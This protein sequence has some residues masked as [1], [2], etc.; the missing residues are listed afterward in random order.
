MSTIAAISTA[1]GVGGIGVIRIS[2]PDSIKIAGKIFKSAD[3]MELSDVKG[4]NAKYGKVY[5]GDSII[6]EAIAL[7]F[8]SPHSYTGEDVVEISCHGGIYIVRKVLDIV[9]KNGA[10]LAESGE[11]TKRAFLN[12][13]I[14]L[15]KAEAIINLIA[16]QGEK[17]REIAISGMEGYINKIIDK[18]KRNLIDIIS[19][20]DVW[21]DYPDDEVYEVDRNKLRININNVI[22]QISKMKDTYKASRAVNEGIKIA[23]VGRPNVGKSSLVNLLLGYSRVIVTDVPGTTRDIIKEQTML[24][25]IPISISDTAGIRDTDDVIEKIGIDKTINCLVDSDIN[26]VV[27][28]GSKGLEDEDIRISVMVDKNK[29]IAIINKIDLNMQVDV[30]AIKKMFDK[31][32][33]IS[34]ITGD[35]ID[36]LEKVVS[37]FVGIEKLSGENIVISSERQFQILYRVLGCLEDAKKD[38][39]DGVTLDAITVLIQDAL[40]I[41]AEITGENVS[42]EIIDNIFS[43]F[44]VGK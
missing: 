7:V 33:F 38:I 2:G 17:A 28:D 24:G 8:I 10:K 15:V 4:Y 3:G 20:L 16:S 31:I 27:F 21:A 26:F 39:E 42:E 36:K 19:E 22:K 6:D 1:I 11:F 14:D 37:D 43:K 13:K 18:V 12:K 9:I 41:I 44:C 25:D 5:D 34:S 29:S 35:G 40:T 23:V 32:I 30:E